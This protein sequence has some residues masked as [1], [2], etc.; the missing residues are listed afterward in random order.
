MIVSPG[1][2]G[3]GL[4]PSSTLMPGMRAG[5]LDDLD[6]RRAVLGLLAD[7]LVVEDHAG[8]VFFIASVERNSI[9]R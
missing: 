1:Q 9:S 6:Q 7:G 8:D 5:L 3:S 2:N 4:V